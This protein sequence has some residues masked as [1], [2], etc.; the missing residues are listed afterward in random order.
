MPSF[1]CAQQR[2][3][4]HLRVPSFERMAATGASNPRNSR[5]YLCSGFDI[6]A[7]RQQKSQYIGTAFVGRRDERRVP[8]LQL[9]KAVCKMLVACHSAKPLMTR[10][11]FRRSTVA[12]LLTSCFTTSSLPLDAAQCSA[13]LPSRYAKRT[14]QLSAR[15]DAAAACG[16]RRAHRVL[17]VHESAL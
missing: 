10:T 7:A 15:E 9:R 3:V 17:V 16:H 11:L 4:L 2:C 14:A 5:S 13:L 6:C 1:S 8:I 12:P